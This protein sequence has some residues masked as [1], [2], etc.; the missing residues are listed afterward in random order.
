VEGV[1]VEVGV[2]GNGC[3]TELAACAH[4]AHGDLAAIRDEDL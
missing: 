4:H 2:H 1:A 3:D